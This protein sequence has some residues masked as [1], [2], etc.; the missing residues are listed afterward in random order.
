MVKRKRGQNKANRGS[1]PVMGSSDQAVGNSCQENEKGEADDL[2]KD[3]G[4]LASKF[5]DFKDVANHLPP[6]NAYNNTT[7]QL[8]EI[9]QF[10]ESLKK[11]NLTLTTHL[12]DFNLVTLGL[13]GNILNVCTAA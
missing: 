12:G 10:R 9:H 11:V 8:A 2:S 4:L 7:E 1:D 6:L 3:I 5:V 13:G